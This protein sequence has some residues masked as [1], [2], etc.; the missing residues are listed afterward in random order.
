[1]NTFKM[2]KYTKH[3][4]HDTFIF[5]ISFLQPAFHARIWDSATAD[6]A[7]RVV[8]KIVTQLHFPT[9]SRHHEDWK[10]QPLW[11]HLVPYFPGGMA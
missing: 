8:I 1:M 10:H 2:V 3:M 5:G 7:V 9:K 4:A 11:F 6:L